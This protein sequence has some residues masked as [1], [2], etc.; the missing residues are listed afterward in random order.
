M[1]GAEIY[2]DKK[3]ESIFYGQGAVTDDHFILIE[4]N[5]LWTGVGSG[6]IVEVKGQR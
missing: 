4:A 1:K 6:T 2:M 3:M 5:V